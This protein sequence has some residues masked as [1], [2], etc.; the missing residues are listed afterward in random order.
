M[1]QMSRP[2]E[3]GS[4]ICRW[5]SARWVIA[6]KGFIMK[7]ASLLDSH[8]DGKGSGWSTSAVLALTLKGDFF[9]VAAKPT[10]RSYKQDQNPQKAIQES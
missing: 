10:R 4:H 7:S 3:G 8:T 1:V 5:E 2:M 6:C 9:F